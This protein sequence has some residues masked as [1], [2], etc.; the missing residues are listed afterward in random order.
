MRSGNAGTNWTQCTITYPAA[1]GYLSP[2]QHRLCLL[3]DGRVELYGA[4][5][6]PTYYWFTCYSS[7]GGTNFGAWTGR[8]PDRLSTWQY[9]YT[10]GTWYSFGRDI[11]NANYY[12][13]WY[14]SADGL[15]WSRK[16]LVETFFASEP[17][18]WFEGTRAHGILRMELGWTATGQPAKHYSADPPYTTWTGEDMVTAVGDPT[19]IRVAGYGTLLGTREFTATS[20][21]TNFAHPHRMT[22]HW[23]N[24]DAN[25]LLPLVSLTE[26]LSVGTGTVWGDTGYC[27]LAQDGN[28]VI[29]VYYSG[30]STNADLW[31]ARIRQP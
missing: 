5:C 16:K 15:T 4:Q 10:N 21:S 7:D 19:V 8:I 29:C 3:D 12:V 24:A 11:S 18:T 23:Y 26:W 6:N 30:V 14:E 17:A 22:I 20:V 9:A 27:G 28:D 13:G 25:Y 2:D 31:W 1:P